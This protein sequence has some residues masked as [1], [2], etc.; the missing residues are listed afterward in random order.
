ML[1]DCFGTGAQKKQQ[2]PSISYSCPQEHHHQ[3]SK[4][5]SSEQLHKSTSLGMFLCFVFRTLKAIEQLFENQYGA[6]S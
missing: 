4:A 5:A 6:A 1:T 3:F 2:Y